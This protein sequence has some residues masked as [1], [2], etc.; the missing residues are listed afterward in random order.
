MNI[1]TFKWYFNK[2]FQL[3]GQLAVLTADKWAFPLPAQTKTDIQ[4]MRIHVFFNWGVIHL[5]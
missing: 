4:V 1:Y 5:R 3:S 2:L